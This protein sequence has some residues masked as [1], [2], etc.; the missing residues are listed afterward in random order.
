MPSF[1]QHAARSR[2]Q[3]RDDG[4]SD[5]ATP[6]TTSVVKRSGGSVRGTADDRKRAAE[7]VP[8]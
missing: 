4:A 3:S 5:A 7:T 8:S 6:I 1:G 2:D